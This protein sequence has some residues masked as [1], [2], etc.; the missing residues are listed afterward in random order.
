MPPIAYPTLF[1]LVA[2]LSRVRAQPAVTGYS[3]VGKGWCHDESQRF[4]DKYSTQGTIGQTDAVDC[5]GWCTG[6]GIAGL[7]GFSFNP[8]TAVCLCWFED[9]IVTST[10]PPGFND[11]D[12]GSSG[13]GEINYSTGGITPFLCY[14]VVSG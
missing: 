13:T 8:D 6:I 9:G 12:N 11:Y 14:K 1:S 10:I 2:V 3:Y 5:G 4:Y 7:L